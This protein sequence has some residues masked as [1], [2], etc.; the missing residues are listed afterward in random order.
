[1]KRQS[2]N[3]VQSISAQLRL[4]DEPLE[5]WQPVRD[6]FNFCRLALFVAGDKRTD[7]FRDLEQKYTVELNG[8][9][10]QAIWEVRHDSKLGLPGPFD[11]DVWFGIMEIINE[12]TDGGKKP[13]PDSI[14][15]G[16]SREFLKRIGKKSGGGNWMLK[17]KESIQRLT[18]TT[19]LTRKAFN[20]PTDGGYL[21]LLTPI[22]LIEECAFKGEPDG[23]GGVNE[24]TWIRLGSYVRK[25][26]DSGY[27]ALLDVRYIRDLSGEITK[28]L[29]PF[30]SYR[31]WL[32]VQR[33]RDSV[34]V[35]WQ[36]LANYLAAIGWDNLIRAKQRL[37]QPVAELIEHKYIDSSS[38]WSGDYFVFR[39]GDKFL[40]EL[41]NRLNAKEQYK[42]WVQGKQAVKQLQLLPKIPNS[43]SAPRPSTD[44][45]EKEIVLTR[46]AIRLALLNQAPDFALLGKHGWTKEDVESLATE[47]KAKRRSS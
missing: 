30:L 8:Q 40:D 33:G 25:N 43:N 7:R 10:F 27:I 45:D 39:V 14:A 2:L 6:D 41:R 4:F 35:H 21:H 46:Q 13:I 24:S 18:V 47:L 15:I 23:A 12:Q 20:C 5:K 34:S 1:M 11:R 22:H 26:L 3:K 32:A 29:I 28:L 17:L 36:E 31:F 38:T 19:C 44:A 9:I 37:K 42:N 16:S